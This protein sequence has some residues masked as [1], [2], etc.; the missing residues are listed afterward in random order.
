M[1]RKSIANVNRFGLEDAIFVP[2]DP[3]RWTSA[4]NCVWLGPSSFRQTAVLSRYYSDYASLFVGYLGVK[5]ARIGDV[6]EELL[7]VQNQV[8]QAAVIKELL[9][10]LNNF[11][12]SG[13]THNDID[14][15]RRAAIIPIQ[16][17]S[18]QVFLANCNDTFPAWFVPDRERLRFS[19]SGKLNFLDFTTKE[20]EQLSALLE[21][22]GLQHRYL[23]QNVSET[24]LAQGELRPDFSA[25]YTL[26][27]KAEFMSR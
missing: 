7:H 9:K 3:P 4:R 25:Q 24:T 5:N 18:G 23:A 10:S 6:V 8:S 21:H 12:E 27:S 14:R 11:F 22:L 2:T 1:S 17:A 20:I 13:A 26:R 15:L 19:F 16:N